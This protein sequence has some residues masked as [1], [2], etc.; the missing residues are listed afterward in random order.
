M[1]AHAAQQRCG[2][3]VMICLEESNRSHVGLVPV[4]Q[5]WREDAR[6]NGCYLPSTMTSAFIPI[7][8]A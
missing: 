8:Y 1:Q 5:D 4:L 6:K 7:V 2:M 3:A